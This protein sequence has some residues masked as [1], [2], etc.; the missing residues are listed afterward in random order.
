LNIAY[1]YNN[2]TQQLYFS[3]LNIYASISNTYS[4]ITLT[5]DI[6]GILETGNSNILVSSNIYVNSSNYYKTLYNIDSNNSNYLNDAYSIL[7]LSSNVYSYSSNKFIEINGLSS[8]SWS[9][10][11]LGHYSII[12]DLIKSVWA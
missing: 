7:A 3:T 5:T 11:N 6:N 12:R 1:N 4:N 9:N 8:S 2:L 10:A